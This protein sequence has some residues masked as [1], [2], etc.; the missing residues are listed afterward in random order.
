VK[1]IS[2]YVLREHVGPFVFALTALTS[3]MILNFISRQFG[4]LV[5]KG[6]PASVI[7]EFFLLSIPF[8]IALT[9]PMSVL[10]AVLYAYS[11]LAAENEVTALKAS[12]VSPWR[13]VTPALAAGLVMTLFLLAFNDQVLPRANH[14]LKTLQDD[15]SQT[16]PTFLLKPQIINAIREGQFYLKAGKIDQSSSKM[17]EV[18]IYDL[19]D[20]TRRRTTYADSGSISLS[21]NRRDLEMQLYHGQ[22]QQ[23][24]TERAGQLNRLFFSNDRI[25]IRDVAKDFEKSKSTMENRGDRELGICAMQKRLRVANANFLDAKADY[26][27]AIHLAKQPPSA[28]PQAMS[29]H[30][31]VKARPEPHNLAFLYCQ[32]LSRLIGVQKAEAADVRTAGLHPVVQDTVPKRATPDTARRDTTHK[33]ASDSAARAQTVTPPP[34]RGPNGTVILGTSRPPAAGTPGAAPIKVPVQT[35]Q[36]AGTLPPPGAAPGTVPPPAQSTFKDPFLA[37]TAAESLR[38]IGQRQ[39]SAAEVI[40]DNASRVVENK[41]RYDTSRR[42][43]NRYEIEIHK[44]FALAAACLI[45]VVLGAPL[46]LR[47]PRGGVGLVLLVSLIVFAL[48]YVGL[49]GGESLANK[50]LVP[51]FWAMW[52]TNVVLTV[53][54][55]VLLLRMGREDSSGRGGHW[56]DRIDALR[57][58]VRARRGQPRVLTEEAA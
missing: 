58:W 23:V 10:V 27:E 14:Q 19:S 39:Q 31:T 25:T 6:L 22:M 18:V 4:E 29:V 26:E 53:V 52:G 30:R 41:L 3:L 49:I 48:Y 16:K 11:R 44:K 21:A 40:A 15:I 36:P 37:K 57:D 43:K 2:K 54:G 51:P 13:I 46:A 5:G 1:I 32:V 8:T 17:R 28:T 24:A 9:L 55:I 7:G 42:A 50:G 38:A 34:P 56:G 33:A 35:Q 45:F 12:G 47:F 20:P